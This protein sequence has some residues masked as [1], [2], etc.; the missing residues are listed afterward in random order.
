MTWFVRVRLDVY[1]SLRPQVEK[2]L[3]ATSRVHQEPRRA[4]GASAALSAGVCR[5][6]AP[7]NLRG[8]L[9]T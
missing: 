5:L 4:M 7:G 6:H 2:E 8:E 9:S 1:A 3:T